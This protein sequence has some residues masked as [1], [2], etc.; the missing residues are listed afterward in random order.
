MKTK[1]LMPIMLTLAIS[2]CGCMHKASDCLDGYLNRTVS[3]GKILFGHQDDLLYGHTWKADLGEKLFEQSDVKSVCG[4]FPAVLGL[5][6]GGLELAKPSDVDSSDN[7]DSNNF[8]LMRRAAVRH[9]ERGGVVTLSWHPRNPLTGGD[10][11]DVSSGKVV[12]SVL[13]GGEKHELM[14]EWLSNLADWIASLKDKDG[15]PVPVIFRPWHEHSGSWFWWGE[16]LCTRD[17]YV[18]LWKMT[19]DYMV[20]ERKLGGRILWAYSPGSG[21]DREH[22]LERYPGDAYVDILGFDCYQGNQD[23]S[24]YVDEMKRSLDV[25]SALGKEKGKIIAVTETGYQGIPD[26][27]WW[28]GSL[29]PAIRDY[30]VAYVLVWRNAC[31]RPVHFFAPY[32]GTVSEADFKIFAAKDRIGLLK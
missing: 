25:V 19:H 24:A 22:Y 2:G 21:L 20:K 6:L 26:P 15:K 1:F 13:P 28:T 4:S 3:K 16:N 7:I 27:D 5:D 23:G 30:P 29:Y 9:Y 8:S 10:A 17:Q 31:D 14:M 12:A 32:P 11:W 18:S